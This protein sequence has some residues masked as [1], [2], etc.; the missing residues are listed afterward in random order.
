MFA[1][2]QASNRP[3]QWL[4]IEGSAQHS[5][6]LPHGYLPQHGR[7]SPRTTPLHVTP[8]SRGVLFLPP[9]RSRHHWHFSCARRR[10]PPTPATR[11]SDAGTAALANSGFFPALRDALRAVCLKSRYRCPS[12][13]RQ[14]NPSPRSHSLRNHSELWDRAAQALPPG[15]DTEPLVSYNVM[16]Y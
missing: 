5:S 3:S 6:C 7:R 14:E 15:L 8:A 10:R 16:G 4:C 9:R 2:V 11:G 1:T 13:Q 12:A